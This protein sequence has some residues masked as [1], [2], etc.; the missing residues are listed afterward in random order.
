MKKNINKKQ[1][2]ALIIIITLTLSVSLTVLMTVNAQTNPVSYFDTYCYVI[3]TPNPVG[4]NQQ[5]YIQFRIDK[6]SP[7]TQGQEGGDH[8][9]GFTVD[10]QMPDGSSETYGPFN[11]DSTSGSWYIFYPTMIGD[12]KIQANFPGQWI[13]GSQIIM[14]FPLPPVDRWYR[15]S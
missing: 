9:E 1:I 15:P 3:A 6:V 12:H 2:L 10:I 5:T 13:N 7:T 4:V 8:F 14:G 11:A